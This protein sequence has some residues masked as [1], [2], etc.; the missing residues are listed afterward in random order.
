MFKPVG[1]YNRGRGYLGFNP[2]V[3]I[4]GV[5]ASKC[6]MLI[7]P[8]SLFQSLGR[9]SGCSS[10]NPNLCAAW[11][12]AVSIP[13][14]GFWVF[15]LALS[16]VITCGNRKFQS[17]G[18]DS[19]CSSYIKGLPCGGNPMFQSLGRDSG[20]SS[21]ASS[22]PVPASVRFQ[23]LGRDSGCSSSLPCWLVRAAVFVSIPRSGFWVFKHGRGHCGGAG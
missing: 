2:S 7:A 23:S 15:K 20:C 11:K 8:L 1:G 6:I 22:A 5:Q 3:G 13:R 17:L 9:D 10:H 21:S 14:S 16:P 12:S 19:G 4:L 18:R